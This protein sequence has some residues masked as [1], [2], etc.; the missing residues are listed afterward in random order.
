MPAERAG[1]PKEGVER[2]R[3]FTRK[4][5]ANGTRRAWY[6]QLDV[7]GFFV[8]LDRHILCERLLNHETDPAVGG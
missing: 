2:L 3:A 1:A 8:M 4:V 6:L 7:R 5:T